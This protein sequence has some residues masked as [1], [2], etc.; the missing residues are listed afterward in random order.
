MI[1]NWE[2]RKMISF[3]ISLYT[4]FLSTNFFHFEFSRIFFAVSSIKELASKSNF[5]TFNFVHVLLVRGF[6]FSDWRIDDEIYAIAELRSLERWRRHRPKVCQSSRKLALIALLLGQQS[7]SSCNP[8]PWL[9]N[10]GGLRWL[11]L[12]VVILWINSFF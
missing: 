3:Q 9:L 12:I 7:I 1:C 11:A 2:F 6:G 8:V 5:R 10:L 4:N